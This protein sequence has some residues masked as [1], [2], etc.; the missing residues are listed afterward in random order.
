MEAK[1]SIHFLSGKP[2]GGKSYYALKLLVDELAFGSRVVI[3]NLDLDMAELNVYL[4]GKYPSKSINLHERVLLIDEE[5]MGKFFT[6]RPHPSKGAK[7]LTKQDWQEGKLPDYSGVCDGGVMYV[8]D[9]VHIKFNARQWMH[10]GQDVLHYLSQHAKLGDTV[11]CI[12]QAVNNVDKQ[13]RSVTQDY[14]VL[15]NLGKEKM[16]AFAMPRIIVR[17]TFLSPPSSNEAPMETGTFK[18][19]VNGLAKCYRTQSGVGIHATGTADMKERPKGLHWMVLVATV[20][21]ITIA[22]FAYGPKL[23]AKV[24]TPKEAHQAK[25][26]PGQQSETGMITSAR[27]SIK[28]AIK[29]GKTN[30]AQAVVVEKS[31]EILEAKKLVEV[32]MVD[33]LLGYWRIVLTDGRVLTQF[34]KDVK[35]IDP[36]RGVLYGVAYIPYARPEPKEIMNYSMPTMGQS[37]SDYTPQKRWVLSPSGNT[38]VLTQ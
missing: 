26:A 6:I 30:E 35:Q 27:N 8:L 22:A 20:T 13:F 24:V 9:E 7:L 3:T 34:D 10:T 29:A 18:I 25:V 1:M 16:S 15:R 4:Q 14:T 38:R 32:Q 23:I 11:I 21:L 31:S 37:E 28:S 12:T 36:I 2:R 19:D 5:Q 33:R 17:N